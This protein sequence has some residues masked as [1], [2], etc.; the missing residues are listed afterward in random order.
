MKE[1]EGEIRLTSKG[2]TNKGELG[3][4]DVIVFSVVRFWLL[5]MKKN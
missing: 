1:C 2:D 5:K 3:A 4:E